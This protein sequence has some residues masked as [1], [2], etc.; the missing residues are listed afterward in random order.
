MADAQDEIALVQAEIAK[1]V[2]ALAKVTRERRAANRDSPLVETLNT[3]IAEAKQ[4]LS[5][6][7]IKLR[8]IYEFPMSVMIYLDIDAKQERQLFSDINK[9]PRKI[10]GN[11]AALRDQRRF[12]HQL[13]SNLVQDA[14][15]SNPKRASCVRELRQS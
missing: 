15:S 5:A 11:L 6:A 7:E 13:A 8:R 1:A 14:H 10:G 4:A 3:A 12:Y 2:E 9:L